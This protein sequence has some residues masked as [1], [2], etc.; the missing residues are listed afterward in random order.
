[1]TCCFAL[2]LP[3]PFLLVIPEG[4]LLLLVPHHEQLGGETP[5]LK[6][7]HLHCRRLRK[8]EGITKSK[9]ATYKFTPQKLQQ[10]AL[11]SPQTANPR[12]N[13]GDSHAD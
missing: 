8:K 9:Q 2:S 6:P 3:L 4:D 5:L 11:S 13:Q 12:A 10:I 1:M 7:K